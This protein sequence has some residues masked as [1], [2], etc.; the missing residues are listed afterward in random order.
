MKSNLE[1]ALYYLNELNW[2]VIPIKTRDKTPLV[3]SWTEF[4]TRKPTEEEVKKWWIVHPDANIGIITG[5]VSNLL[6]VDIDPKNG[7]SNEAFKHLNTIKVSTGGGGWHYY[8]IFE[9]GLRNKA[10]TQQ[11]IDIRAEGGYVVA[12][13][14]LH[15]SGKPY[16][17]I[18]DPSAGT[19]L[20][21]LPSF[22]K[23]WIK[24]SKS[25]MRSDW[26]PEVLEGV[27]EGS[28]N[29]TAASVI[30]KL[31]SRFPED[32]WET[33]VWPLMLAWNDKNK[34]P[35][36]LHEL[37]SVF[38]SIRNREKY[39]FPREDILGK[40]VAESNNPQIF[41]WEAFTNQ[42]E[43]EE[44]WLIDNLLRPG[45]LAVLGGHGKHGKTTLALHLL[46]AFRLGTNFITPCRAVPV[47]HINYEMSSNDIRI[48]LRTIT[49]Y[50]SFEGKRANIINQ[51]VFPFSF[52]WL[53]SLLDKQEPGVCVIDSFRAAFM[54]RGDKENQSGEIGG[55]LRHLQRIART[56]GWTILIIHHFKKSGTGEALDLAGSS[57]WLS[58]PDV[59]YTWHCPNI[60]EAGTF[61]ITGRVPPT[62][63]L[64][65]RLSRERIEFV[66]TVNE[67]SAENERE[68]IF[69]ALGNTWITADDINH[70]VKFPTSTIRQRLTELYSA[71]RIER[72]G[73][74][75]KGKPYRWRRK[76]KT[77]DTPQQGISEDINSGNKIQSASNTNELIAKE[78][79]LRTQ[80]QS[81]DKSS[82]AYAEIYNKWFILREQG[83]EKKLFP[84]FI[85]S[86]NDTRIHEPVMT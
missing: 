12:P 18:I 80:L 78:M 47:I 9:D 40:T 53:E 56:T 55:I 50:N 62:E 43:K 66:G 61:S 42:E 15:E 76:T 46:N 73:E 24:S 58:A 2:S 51:P 26:N 70:V 13:P 35:L 41:S 44:P 27:K 52:E 25:N 60:K 67:Q 29:D 30:G 22:V 63:P 54:L 36:T 37:S 82:P 19:H 72:Q 32:E 48:L 10:G 11:G 45:W 28:R 4:Q 57:E 84:F 8:F 49:N 81:L 38:N 86:K 1:I 68:K 31:L 74:G 5:K 75:K 83:V 65:I 6:V 16:E 17:W 23:G 7:G 71:D 79:K 3:A 33:E 69:N 64:A 39:S 77:A 14:S 20:T 34:P 59:I 21:P 85:P